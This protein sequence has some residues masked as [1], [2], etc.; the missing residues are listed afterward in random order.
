MSATLVVDVRERFVS[1]ACRQYRFWKR[2][3][4]YTVVLEKVVGGGASCCGGLE[5]RKCRRDQQ[6]DDM[7]D[8]MTELF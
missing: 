1:A 8:Q 3:S 6:G 4:V 7:A 2:C 5:V